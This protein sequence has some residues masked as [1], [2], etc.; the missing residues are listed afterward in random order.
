MKNGKVL[1]VVANYGDDEE[2]VNMKIFKKVPKRLKLYYA[3]ESSQIP[4]G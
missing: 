2:H 4:M 3:T 1:Y